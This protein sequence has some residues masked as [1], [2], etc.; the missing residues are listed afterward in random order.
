MK[1]DIDMKLYY[2]YLNGNKEAF[3]ILYNKYKDKII[4]FIYNIIND[5]EK[6]ED[7]TQDVFIYIL[8]NEVKQGHSFKY[9]IYLIAKSRAIN[10]I[11]SRNTR[12]DIDKMYVS[13]ENDEVEKDIA[14]IVIANETKKEIIDAINTLDE[15][16]RNVMYLI[17]IEELSYKETAEILG[18]NVQNIKNIVHKN[19][20]KLKD[21]LAKKG[22]GEIYKFSKILIIILCVSVIWSGVVFAAI[23]IYETIKSYYFDEI[24]TEPVSNSEAPV[25]EIVYKSFDIS[26]SEKTIN[27]NTWGEIPVEDNMDKL[28]YKKITDYEEYKNLMNNYSKLRTL[29]ESD[30]ENYFAVVILSENIDKTLN[31]KFITYTDI[32]D[33]EKMMQIN[34]T[35]KDNENEDS[36]Y[37]GLVVIMTRRHID[38]MIQPKLKN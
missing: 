38:Y 13:K 3:E 30:F 2:E 16:S 28:Y 9:Y 20:K 32:S 18:E 5:Y 29:N 11:N 1:N 33:D 37:S 27:F 6:A 15:R 8:K 22:F 19:K 14:D 17:K 25:G 10:H 26:K 4:Y 23:K 12:A 35:Y 31:Y 34:I 21:V 7:I 24:V 36:K